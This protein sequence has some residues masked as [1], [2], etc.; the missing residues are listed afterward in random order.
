MVG[1]MKHVR[2][3]L[4]LNQTQDKTITILAT[5]SSAGGSHSCSMQ[6][7]VAFTGIMPASCRTL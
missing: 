2:L 5:A 4:P 6:A 1:I 3:D 7:G